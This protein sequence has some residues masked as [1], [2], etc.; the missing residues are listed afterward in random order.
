MK[1]II[2]IPTNVYIERC[3]PFLI[4]GCDLSTILFFVFSLRFLVYG[5]TSI[6]FLATFLLSPLDV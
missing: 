3:A 1:L 5:N 4:I 2:S 6:I